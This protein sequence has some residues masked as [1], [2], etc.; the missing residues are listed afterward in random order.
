MNGFVNSR[1]GATVQFQ[2]TRHVYVDFSNLSSY[3]IS[4]SIEDEEGYFALL[5]KYGNEMPFQVVMSTGGQMMTLGYRE[6]VDKGPRMFYF[7]SG[8]NSY[9]CR[10]IYY[11]ADND[12]TE[13]WVMY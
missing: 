10:R 13:F 1:G 7:S 8:E 6:S 5:D 12:Q 11:V 4:T 3:S 9:L 2:G